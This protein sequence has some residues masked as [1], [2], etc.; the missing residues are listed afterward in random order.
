MPKWIIDPDHS[1]AAF[2]VRHMMVSNV[3]GQFNKISGTIHFDPSEVAQSTLEAEIDVSGIFTGIAKRDEHLLSPDFFDVSKYPKILFKSTRI[4]PAGGNH[5]R[6]SGNL[7]I[8]GITHPVTFD[9]EY[10]GP[11]KGT[12]EGE[13]VIGFTAITAINRQDYGVMWNVN[14]LEKGGVVVDN[15]VT[16]TLSVEADPEG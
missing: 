8:H 7:T 13:T 6:T 4:D 5:F 9:T 10:L 14:L 3:H 12:E 16:I 2:V 15:K 11:V 1:V